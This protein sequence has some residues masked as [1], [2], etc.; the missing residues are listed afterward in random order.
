MTKQQAWDLP[1]R[2]RRSF[3]PGFEAIRGI[4]LQFVRENTL[5]FLQCYRL[6]FW[7]PN[8][9]PDLKK[10]SR[11]VQQDIITE[12]YNAASETWTAPSSRR[13]LDYIEPWEHEFLDSGNIALAYRISRKYRGIHLLVSTRQPTYFVITSVTHGV[14][15][16]SLV[17]EPFYTVRATSL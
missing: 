12:S 15:R 3:P 2:C 8:A 14:A 7:V 13:F 5:L 4:S 17:A 1:G 16:F 11:D 6:L 10:L 9:S